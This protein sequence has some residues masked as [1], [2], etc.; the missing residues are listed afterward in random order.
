MTKIAQTS[1]DRSVFTKNEAIRMCYFRRACNAVSFWRCL[2]IMTTLVLHTR[3]L[4]KSVRSISYPYFIAEV[5]SC[6]WWEDYR[7]Y[8]RTKANADVYGFTVAWKKAVHV[9]VFIWGKR[10][11]QLPMFVDSCWMRQENLGKEIQYRSIPGLLSDGMLISKFM[12]CNVESHWTSAFT[13]I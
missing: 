3:V 5:S 2:P 10:G 11:G 7:W 12:Y 1:R 9:D 6:F 13:R 4:D 8:L